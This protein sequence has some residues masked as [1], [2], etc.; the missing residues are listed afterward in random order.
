MKNLLWPSICF[1]VLRNSEVLRW[2]VSICFSGSDQKEKVEEESDYLVL[3]P[4]IIR[5]IESTILVFRL[6]LKMDNKKHGS[7]RNM[8]GNQNPMATPLQQV[9]S[10]LE[11]V[12]FYF[13]FLCYLCYSIWMYQIRVWVYL[14]MYQCTFGHRYRI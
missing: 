13:N 6:F 9:Q 12:H 2:I 10:L 8:F 3:A 1:S 14:G 5:I 4:D 11:K 7:F